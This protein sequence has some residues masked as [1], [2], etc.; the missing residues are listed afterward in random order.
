MATKFGDRWDV[1]ESLKESGQAW[2]YKV[3]DSTTPSG[4]VFV[5]KRLKNPNRLE[6]FQNEVSSLKELTHP[7]ITRLL[8][9]DLADERPWFVQEYCSG[10]DLEDHIAASGPM[11]PAAAL[12]TVSQVADALAYAHKTG[13][14]HR[15]IKPA[16]VYLR[17]PEG[18]AVLGDFGLTWIDNQGSRLTLTDEAVGSFRFM[19]PE[20]RD[21]RAENP[22]WHSDIYSLG[23]LLYALLSGGLVFDREDHR[24]DRWNLVR[25]RDSL[26]L[27]HVNN[28]LDHM[29]TL[30]PSGR[31]PAATV[32]TRAIQTIRLVTREFAPLTGDIHSPCKYCGLGKYV[33]IV[34]SDQGFI[35]FFGFLPDAISDVRRNWRLMACDRCG[36]IQFFTMGIL[37][38]S[39]FPSKPH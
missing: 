11:E 36:N 34:W 35:D 13:R 37:P 23:K 17:S 24:S 14:V 7:N 32:Q 16:N 19:A 22:T 27:E 8:D 25:I 2:S 10:G 6:R 15:D 29:I 31:F 5:L 1:I 39:W 20:L 28:L 26:S 33:P 12:Y 9:F 4:E 3:R 18:Q 21:G 38:E 30:E